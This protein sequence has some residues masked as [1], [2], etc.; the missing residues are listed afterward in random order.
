MS[1]PMTLHAFLFPHIAALQRRYAVTVVA[2]FPGGGSSSAV[3]GAEVASLPI[4]RR[5]SPLRDLAALAGLVRLFRRTH[6]SAI[7]SVTP[8]A[9]LLT[10]LAGLLARVPV[11]IHVFTGQ[12]WANRRGAARWFLKSMDR[13]IARCATHVLVDSPSQRD[14][15][16]AEGV[17]NADCSRVL[18]KGSISGVDAS[19]FRPDPDA[20]GSVRAKLGYP[21]DSVVFLYLGRL[22]R[23]KGVLD[24]A[25]AFSRIAA[26]DRKLGL[27]VVGPDEDGV[28]AAMRAALDAAA[29]QAR[30]VSYTD[31]PEQY[32]AA[33]DV[34]CLPSYREGFG[35]TI[36]EAAA[37][38]VPAIGSKIYGV[39]DAI[40]EGA[41]GLLFEPGNIEALADC[42]NRLARDP[43]LRLAMGESARVKALRDFPESAITGE[44]LRL[45]EAAIG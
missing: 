30:F 21:E 25:A 16:I 1:S 31:H 35:T 43:A 3:P 11:R 14:F 37:C 5:I 42:L 24:L 45:Y 33:A 27:L 38:A 40:D 2:N 39:T 9:G 32:M 41:T 17:V 22:S 7:Q 13:V 44:L 28:Q 20:R 19:R 29:P 4:E 8:K 36:I 10:M 18:G 26:T 15:L 6:F 12:V 34:F 23:D